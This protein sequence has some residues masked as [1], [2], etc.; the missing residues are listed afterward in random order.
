MFQIHYR[1][2]PKLPL[3][4]SFPTCFIH[5]HPQSNHADYYP[6]IFCGSDIYWHLFGYRI[7]LMVGPKDIFFQKFKFFDFIF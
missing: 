4:F 5:H 6:L 7:S 3:T 1:I 2:Q